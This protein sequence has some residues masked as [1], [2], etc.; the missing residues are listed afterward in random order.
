MI[1]STGMPGEGALE[2]E[3]LRHVLD[4]VSHDLGG[5]SSAL[6]LRAD[7]MER[8]LPSASATACSR[9]ATELRVLGAQLRA[10]SGPQGAETLSPTRT[11]SLELWFAMVSRFGQPLLR[12][13]VALR[14]AVDDVTIGSLAAHE[15]TFV[16]LGLLHAIRDR[17]SMLHTEIRVS[18]TLAEHTVSI[19]IA[20]RDGAQQS[21]PLTDAA[22][23]RWWAWAV[24]RATRARVDMRVD[25]DRVALCV[26]LENSAVA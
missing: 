24:D 10:I 2:A 26:G 20:L 16:M 6:A 21:L 22:Q 1:P 19:W 4:A 5:L 15:L 3:L 9:I 18:S 23:S 14:G 11:G 13:G 17:A 7:V 12:R 25:G 8:T